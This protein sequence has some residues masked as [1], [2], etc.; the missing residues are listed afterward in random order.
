MESHIL[1]NTAVALLVA[2]LAG[3]VLAVRRSRMWSDAFAE[4]WHR[5][6]LALCVIGGY[7][8]IALLD[9]VA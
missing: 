9:S 7:V 3:L 4:I 2:G 6:R 5:R 8:L 1:S